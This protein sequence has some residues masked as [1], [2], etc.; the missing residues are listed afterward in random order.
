[1]RAAVSD[2][3]IAFNPCLDIPLPPEQPGEQRFLAAGGG[4]SP[5]Q[6]DRYP[7]QGAGVAGCLWRATFWRACRFGGHLRPPVDYPFRR[8][9]QSPPPRGS[10][11]RGDFT[12]AAV[13]LA[14]AREDVLAFT[15]FP[16]AHWKQIWSNN[17]L[18]RLNKEIRRRTDVVGIFPNRAAVIRL[19]GAVLAEQHDEWAVARRYV[20]AESLAKARVVVI[21]GDDK[22]AQKEVSKE[23][24]AAS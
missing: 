15:A 2:R 1:M 14:D 8:E 12:D 20:S 3:R 18:E 17:P 6:H 19:V 10:R 13:L 9:G 4:R 16:Q 21:E 23:L 7:L 22:D 11:N 24:E 5:R